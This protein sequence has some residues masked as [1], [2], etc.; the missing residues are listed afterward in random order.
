[1]KV[2]LR[3]IPKRW[4]R[5][6]VSYGLSRLRIPVGPLDQTNLDAV[7]ALAGEGGH[8]LNTGDRILEVRLHDKAK[9]VE[10]VQLWCSGQ[11]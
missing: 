10:V 3:L 4:G 9:I 1:M 6:V 2:C 11:H 7:A 5:H 8:M